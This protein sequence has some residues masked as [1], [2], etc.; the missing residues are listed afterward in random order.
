MDAYYPVHE[1]NAKTHV[2]F[3]PPL[4]FEVKVYTLLHF[5]HLVIMF[6]ALTRS[7]NQTPFA[8]KM[9]WSTI[10][11][12]GFASVGTFMEGTKKGWK[13]EMSR[14]MVGAPLVH[15]LLHVANHL[16]PTLI[17][18]KMPFET[19]Q[20]TFYIGSILFLHLVSEQFTHE[21][22]PTSGEHAKAKEAKID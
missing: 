15:F 7:E 12:A 14:V 20:L 13:M 9:V 10:L 16:W 3:D 22:N 11:L 6:L 17:G 8:L 21:T 5:I 19:A 1:V 4:S 18:W 2:K